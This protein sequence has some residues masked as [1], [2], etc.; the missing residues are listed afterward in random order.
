[1]K[2]K[3]E[4]I[5]VIL[6]AVFGLFLMYVV[7]SALNNLSVSRHDS[8][9]IKALFTDLKQLQ[10]GDD[11]RIAGVRVGSVTH[12]YLNKGLAVAVLSIEKKYAIPEDS[13]ATILMAGLLGANYISIVPG[14][15]TNMMDESGFLETQKVS[16]VSSVIQK[17]SSIGDRLNRILSGFDGSDEGDASGRPNL[18]QELGDF[19]HNNKDKLEKIVDNISEITGKISEGQGTLGR[20]INEDQAYNDLL[21]TMQSIKTAALKVDSILKNFDDISKNIKDG[22]GLLC[23]LISD[24]KTAQSFEE[25][26]NNIKSF[27]NKL[28]SEN[29]TLGR[30][31]SNDDLYKQAE[32]TLGKVEK[33][34]DS[35][36]NS[37]P[38][39]AVG[40]A[41]S[42][43]F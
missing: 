13:V 16:D 30:I 34:V 25:I 38:I 26:L 36:S 15:S 14:I 5:R 21:D 28:N 37:G 3:Y 41:A 27:S 2:T 6:F 12:T 39:T 22:D 7:Y 35:V 42:A 31:I 33:A 10:I 19:F 18:F 29:S 32:A 11:V 24:E 40:A 17:F 1:M 8:Y 9:N 20:L 43:L 23:K 4:S